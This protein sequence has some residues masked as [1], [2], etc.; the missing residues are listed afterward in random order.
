MNGHRIKSYS[1]MKS[2]RKWWVF[3]RGLTDS[4]LGRGLARGV[5]IQDKDSRL[6]GIGA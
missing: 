2:P 5:G 3:L 1:H 6:Q 4:A